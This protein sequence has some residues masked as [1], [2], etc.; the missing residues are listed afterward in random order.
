MIDWADELGPVRTG[1][2][3]IL[4]LFRSPVGLPFIL[5]RRVMTPTNELVGRRVR[6]IAW[7]DH[8]QLIAAYRTPS[9]PEGTIT[10]VN[11]LIGE[12]AVSVQIDEQGGLYTFKLSDV[13]IVP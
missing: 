10:H 7:Y 8:A 4:V 2:R 1:I 9:R 5:R 6:V 3:H 11:S 13:E 12:A